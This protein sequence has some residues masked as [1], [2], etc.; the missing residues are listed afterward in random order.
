MSDSTGAN[1]R[2]PQSTAFYKFAVVWTALVTIIPAIFGFIMLG[3]H[4]AVTTPGVDVA[5][6]FRAMAY[7][8]FAFSA[9]LGLALMTQ[10]KQVVAFLLAARG[11]TEWADGISGVFV[12]SSGA[13]FAPFVGGF[14]DLLIAYYFF[15]ISIASDARN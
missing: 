12:A 10:P 15:R 2:P 13:A 11:L 6:V 7:R 1:P 3:H 9:V 5:A 4:E 14:G 8:N